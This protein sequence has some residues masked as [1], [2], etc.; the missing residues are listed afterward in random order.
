MKS[1]L[2]LIEWLAYYGFYPISRLAIA[3]YK[4]KN[5]A[6]IQKDWLPPPKEFDAFRKQFEKLHAFDKVMKARVETADK[7]LP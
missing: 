4:R 1:M 7:T 5:R 2:R 6:M 3:R